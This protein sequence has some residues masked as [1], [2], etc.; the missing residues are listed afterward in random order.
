MI[1][2]LYILFD[3]LV[4]NLWIKLNY[5]RAVCLGYCYSSLWN[6]FYFPEL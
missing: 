1:N 2:G 4:F 3:I 6:Y 5:Q